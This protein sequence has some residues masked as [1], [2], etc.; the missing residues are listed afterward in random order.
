MAY[1]INSVKNHMCYL[2]VGYFDKSNF[3]NEGVKKKGSKTLEKRDPFFSM[4]IGP[5]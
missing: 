1:R 4:V 3:K 2:V 5:F